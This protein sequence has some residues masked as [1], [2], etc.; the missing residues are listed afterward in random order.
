MQGTAD[1]MWSTLRKGQIGDAYALLRKYY[2][3]TIINIYTNLVIE[4]NFNNEEPHTFKNPTVDGWMNG[5]EQLPEYRV[6]SQ[7][8]KSSPKLKSVTDLLAK[9]NR[10]R[11]VRDRCNDHTHYNFYRHVLLNDGQIH[12]ERIVS[13]DNFLYDLDQIFT[14]HFVYLFYL[15]G[16]YMTASDYVDHMEVGMTP[17]DDSQYWVAPYIQTAFDKYVKPNRPDLAKELIDSTSMELS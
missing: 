8:V 13:L 10:Y 16:H 3:S 4:D 5:G 12:Q 7:Y 11:G 17:P 15:N 6:M 2:D 9:D 1:S 14:Q